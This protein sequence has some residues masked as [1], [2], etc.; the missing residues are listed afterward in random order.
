MR[1]VGQDCAVTVEIG[2][3]Q[4]G[5]PNYSA[6]IDMTYLYKRGNIDEGAVEADVSSLGDDVE[7]T[8]VKRARG[9]VV[10]C[11]FQIDSTVGTRFKDLIGYYGRITF[12]PFSGLAVTEQIAGVI[13][14]R[15]W[16]SPDDEQ[17]ETLTIKGGA[18]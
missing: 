9:K 18:D 14:G 17:I 16:E 4:D 1:A 5:T 13:T 12:T 7:R 11:D 2:G 8:R 10:Q 15:R 3:L 6:P